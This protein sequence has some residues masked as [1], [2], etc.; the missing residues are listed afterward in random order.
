MTEVS[1]AQALRSSPVSMISC[2]LID[3]VTELQ[4]QVA[5]SLLQSLFSKV[6]GSLAAS[7]A[8]LLPHPH[9]W[10]SAASLQQCAGQLRQG[11][12]RLPT[13]LCTVMQRSSRAPDM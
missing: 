12:A 11:Q 3:M 7:G 5:C 2:A 9:M 1:G 10:F 13:N 6:R 4:V 8:A